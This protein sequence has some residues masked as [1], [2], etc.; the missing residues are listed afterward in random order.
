[1]LKTRIGDYFLLFGY[2]VV[3]TGLHPLFFVPVL[4]YT[5]YTPVRYSHMKYYTIRADLLPHTE[6][7]VFKKADFFGAVKNI[8]CDIKDLQKIDE[9]EVPSQLVFFSRGF[10]N[11]MI[12]RDN[13]T[14]EVFFFEKNGVWSEKGIAHPLIN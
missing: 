12:F 3:I 4:A 8:V 1:V 6:Q 7:V 2:T 10:D 11:N 9:S 5:L 14:G 13:S